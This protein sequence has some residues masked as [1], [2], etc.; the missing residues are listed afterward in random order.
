MPK[1]D[2]LRNEITHE[3][4]Y[5][6]YSVNLGSIKM[7]HDVKD[8]YWWIGMKSDIAN[9]VS[10]CLTYQKVKFEHQRPLKSFRR[11]S[12]LNKNGK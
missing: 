3:A 11:F 5:T 10:K 1:V 7:Y 4:Y 8:R 2:N 6:P 9:F 12:F